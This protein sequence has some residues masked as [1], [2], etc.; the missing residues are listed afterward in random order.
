MPQP[1]S[2]HTFKM[3]PRVC[4]LLF[5]S[6]AYSVST[7]E[8]VE[9]TTYLPAA[10]FGVP[11]NGSVVGDNAISF[12][13][14]TTFKIEIWVRDNSGKAVSSHIHRTYSDFQHFD[15]L[16]PWFYKFKLP[17]EDSADALALN[18]YLQRVFQA[19]ALVDT[20]LFSDFLGINWDGNDCLYMR[21]FATFMKMLTRDRIPLF[22]PEPP[23]FATEAD[24]VVEELCPFENY[25][26]LKSFRNDDIGLDA[27]LEYYGA[28][29]D[30]L[31]AFEGKDH[32]HS[33]V[34]LPG[35]E[36]PVEYPY[37]YVTTQVHFNPGRFLRRCQYT[38]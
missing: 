24:A 27:Y 13:G 31:P 29:V 1:I 4:I 7:V 20:E 35:A 16:K 15:G 3:D 2:I 6:T 28:Y 23:I 30:S 8:K 32:T 33:D 22:A 10:I 34:W 25:I 5:L 36:A 9:P 26:F 11:L 18:D 21:D 37:H 14:Q 19:R 12:T 38:N 17:D